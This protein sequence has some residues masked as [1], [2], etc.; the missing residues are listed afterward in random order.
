[1]HKGLAIWRGKF[2]K[3]MSRE[4]LYEVC[5]ELGE[6]VEKTRKENSEQSISHLDD[7]AKISRRKTWFPRSWE[8]MRCWW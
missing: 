2:L 1:M 4:E 8:E 5:E 6:M 7:L 3:D